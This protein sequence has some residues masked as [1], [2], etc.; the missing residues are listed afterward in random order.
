MAN[1]NLVSNTYAGRK[2]AEY[3]T[4][5]LLPKKG[6]VDRG[7][8]TLVEGQKNVLKLLGVDRSLEFQTPAAVFNAQT[9]NIDRD[10]KALNLLRYEV[11]DQI[12][13]DNVVASWESEELKKGSLN[14]YVAPQA[15]YDFLLERIYVPKMGIMNE[16]LYLLGKS[17]VSLGSATFTGTYGGLLAEIEADT[18][19]LRYSLPNTAQMALTG[20][21]SA[22]PAVVTVAS[23]N[24][25]EVG[26]TITFIGLNGTL[27]IGGVAI[28]GQSAQVVAKTATTLT[29]NVATTGGAATSGTIFFVNAANVISVLS[30]VYG[31]IPDKIRLS[32]G[33]KILFGSNIE[34]A[35]RVATASVATGSG[36][37]FRNQYFA[38][39]EGVIPYL[40]MQ[41]ESMPYWKPNAIAVWNPG[42]VFLGVD[43]ISDEVTTKITWLGDVTNDQV[44]RIRNSMKSGIT[45]K[46]S[47]EVLWVRP[48]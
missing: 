18:A 12:A 38:N 21:T 5:A 41:C 26:D 2:Y 20:V 40:D 1:I 22:N 37:H 31:L 29:T 44:Y 33:S 45:Y 11:M 32:P 10:E 16:Q 4:P 3:L 25:I 35:Y 39:Q 17:G 42:N 9:G 15:L 6:L 19:A 36:D 23:T 13:F 46:Y 7:L 27:Q 47:N 34:K 24:G 43:V 48:A 8:V 30:Y 28:N 14:D